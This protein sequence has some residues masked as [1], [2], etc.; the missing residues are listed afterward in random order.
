MLEGT[1]SSIITV[2]TNIS[3][4]LAWKPSED[5]IKTA[6]KATVEYNRQHHKQ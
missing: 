3:D 6:K 4:P 5:L 1:L 2:K